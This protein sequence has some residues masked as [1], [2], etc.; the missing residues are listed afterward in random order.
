[1]AKPYSAEVGRKI[2]AELFKIFGG[3]R[4]VGELIQL[5][6]PHAPDEYRAGLA[7]GWEAART[8]QHDPTELGAPR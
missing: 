1:M 8:G 3:D 6:E 5:I 2:G 4:D 7:E